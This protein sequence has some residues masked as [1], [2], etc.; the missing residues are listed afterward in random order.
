MKDYRL[1]S[2]RDAMIWTTKDLW[3]FFMFGSIF[4]L[5]VGFLSG[6]AL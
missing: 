4:G 3:I 5:L 6:V 1:Q 2:V